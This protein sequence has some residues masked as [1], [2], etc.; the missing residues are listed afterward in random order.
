[1]DNSPI[2]WAVNALNSSGHQLITDRPKTIQHTPWSQVYCFTTDKGL[3][4]LKITPPALSLESTIINILHEQFQANVPQIIAANPAL[5]CFLMQDAGVPLHDYL[6]QAFKADVLGKAIDNYTMLQ[7]KTAD[8]IDMFLDLGVPDW[9]LEKLP[10]LYQELIS[11]EKMLMD[12]G[13]TKNDLE[14]LHVL[15][16]KLDA[17]CEELSHYKMTETFGHA[18]FHDKNILYNPN[19][20]ET[21][22]IDLG[23]VVIT[24]P[25][26]SLL[27]CLHRAKMNF[28]LSDMQYRQLEAA[29]L[30]PWLSLESQD[31]LV[32]ILSII[33]RCWSIHSVLGEF[34]L[35]QSVDQL[36]KQGRLARNLRVWINQ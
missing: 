10:I 23:E 17:I 33:Q 18:D 6:K 3:V 14:Q 19:T 22:L 11:H 34:R 27:N 7:L 36:E 8:K 30:K 24:H 32:K 26:F 5:H 35:I 13:L 29:C 16:P 2:N 9:R 12:D 25:F 21:T 28:S 15:R 4:F 1:M 31:N 20:N